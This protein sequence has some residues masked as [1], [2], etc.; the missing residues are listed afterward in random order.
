MSLSAPKLQ[1]PCKKYIEFKGD[2]GVFQYWDKEN[3]KNIQ[4]KLPISFIVLDELNTI[5]GFCEEA[6]S[7]IYSNE[8]HNLKTQDLFVRC[9]KGRKGITGKYA[10]IKGDIGSLGGRFCKSVYAAL[11]DGESLEMVNF[12]L[13]GAAFKSWVDKQVDTSH[14]A[15]TCNGCIDGKK[16]KVEYKI[17]VWEEETVSP[18]L[19]KEAIEMDRKLQEFLRSKKIQDLDQVEVSKS[20]ESDEEPEQDDPF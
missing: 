7:G 2:D 17:P 3:K 20:E 16:G 10:D 15:V 14:G 1:S 5:K 11:I 8:I 18:N 9:F 4:L 13:M 6:Q 12:Q 19:L